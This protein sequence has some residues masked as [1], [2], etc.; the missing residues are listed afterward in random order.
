MAFPLS[1]P[2]VAL[3]I[4]FVVAA[5]YDAILRRIPNWLVAAGFVFGAGCHA[6]LEPGSGLFLPGGGALGLDQALLGG[7]TG[8]GIFLPFFLLRAIGAGDAKLMAAVGAFLGPLQVTGAALLAFV[9]GGLLSLGTALLTRTL[10]QVVVNLRTMGATLVAGRR[11]G[12]RLRD[13]PTTGR[14]PYAYAIAF[15]TALQIWLAAKGGWAFA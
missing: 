9:C 4:L 7:L 3:A 6:V 15:G 14:L 12:L 11:S 1:P 8:L 5:A 10:P 13:V 2:S